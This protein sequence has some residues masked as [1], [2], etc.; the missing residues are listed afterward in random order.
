MFE[1]KT[2][3]YISQVGE[4]I[5]LFGT[6]VAGDQRKPEILKLNPF[7]KVPFINDGGFVLTERYICYCHLSLKELQVAVHVNHHIFN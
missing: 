2:L 1:A 4:R 5:K 7:G 3:L 6:F